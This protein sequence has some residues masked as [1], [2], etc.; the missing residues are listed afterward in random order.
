MGKKKIWHEDD[1]FWRSCHSVLFSERRL[2]E[3]SEEVE[4]IVTL[5]G[6]A[7]DVHILDLC[8]GVGRHTLELARRGFS[9]VGVDRTRFYLE[10]ASEEAR[11]QGLE[12]EFVEEDM[13]TFVRPEG[14]DA[15]LNLFTSFGYFDD[16]E[17][18]ARVLRNVHR[19]LKPGG[20]LLMEL[21]G[22]EVLATIFRERD[23]REENGRILLEER[24]V[25]R[26][27]GWMENR[28]IMLTGGR[29]SE[30]A[31]THRLYSAV[32][33]CSL[34]TQCGFVSASPFGD[35]GGT[36]YDQNARRLVVLA[37]KE[38]SAVP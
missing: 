33:L 1:R 5:L 27:W 9:V 16:P 29:R 4:K 26:H 23:W 31:V 19:S 12:V 13:R 25:S 22:K 37:R 32:E 17:E 36:P 35:L 15:V 7:P 14:F 18:D 24:R 11:N 20:A 8:C 21:M 6:L 3:A 30:F 10:R 2:E 28:W 34:L 38:R